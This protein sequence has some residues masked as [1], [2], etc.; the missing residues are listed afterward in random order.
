MVISLALIAIITWITSTKFAPAEL[1]IS[2]IVLRPSDTFEIHYQQQ[3]KHQ[4]TLNSLSFALILRE[5]ITEG[6]GRSMKTINHD[7]VIEEEKMPNVTFSPDQP[8]NYSHTYTIPPD[9]T[10]SYETDSNKLLWLLQVKMDVPNFPDYQR[11]YKLQVIS[12]VN[13]EI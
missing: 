9:A 7:T 4:T 1:A 10:H 5:S 2:S 11:E 8:I 6:S 13:N 3:V 12:E